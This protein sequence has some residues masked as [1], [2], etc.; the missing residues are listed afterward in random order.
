MDGHMAGWMGWAMALAGLALLVLLLA[1]LG[2]GFA[3]GRRVRQGLDEQIG[4]GARRRL[5]G[6]RP[7]PAE[8]SGTFEALLLIPDITGYTHFM[9]ISRFALGHAQYLVSELLA[10]MIEAGGERLATLK[11]EGDAVFMYAPARSGERD[12]RLGRAILAVLAAFYRRRRELAAVNVCDCAACS[13]LGQLDV[14]AVAACGSVL[15]HEV[16][17]RAEL[18]GLPVIT[19]HRLLKAEVGRPRYL[20][21]TA[22]AAACAAPDSARPPQRLESAPQDLPE[23]GCLVYDLEVEELLAA[24]PPPAPAGAAA[25]IG[26]LGRK[27]AASLG[28]LRHGGRQA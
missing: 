12:P 15:F 18:T 21:M 8:P 4:I 11:I 16:A 5:A 26:D 25:R 22:A 9:E 1:L 13:A 20:L 19:V 10:A 7:P 28:A 6:R 3:L 27:L 17:E 14:K 2:L 24:E 23:L